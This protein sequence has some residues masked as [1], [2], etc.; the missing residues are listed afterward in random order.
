MKFSSTLFTL[1]IISFLV[2]IAG[3]TCY[4]QPVTFEIMYGIGLFVASVIAAFI[5][6]AWRI[7][8]ETMDI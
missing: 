5:D 2:A 8:D 4:N 6:G 3:K 7:D 1:S